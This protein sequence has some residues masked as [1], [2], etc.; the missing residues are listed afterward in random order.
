MGLFRQKKKEAQ[1]AQTPPKPAK[2][3]VL[4]CDDNAVLR[5]F[6]TSHLRELG[7]EIHEAADG[8]QGVAAYLNLRPD[9]TLMDIVMPGMDG[10]EALRQIKSTD[11]AARVLI[12]SAMG[13]KAMV[14]SAVQAGA[15]NFVVKPKSL[16]ELL[17]QLL[18][19]MPPAQK[20]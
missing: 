10:L 7:Y 16:E 5:N 12:V 11:P 14:V 4:I 8:E 18:A 19:K 20:E 3:R 6:L 15:Q 1:A 9:I 17:P 13:N 2:T